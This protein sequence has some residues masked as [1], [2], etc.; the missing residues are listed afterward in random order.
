MENKIKS[1]TRIE[2]DKK[3]IETLRKNGKYHTPCYSECTCKLCGNQYTYDTKSKIIQKYFDKG[4]CSNECY[5]KSGEKKIDKMRT[6]LLNL[7]IECGDNNDVMMKYSDYK[8]EKTKKCADKWRETHIKKYGKDFAS[9]R[10]KLSWITHIKNFLINNSIVTEDEYN[11]LTDD[12]IHNLF[13]DN[14]NPI[15]SHG[16]LIKKGRMEKYGNDLS[17]YKKSYVIGIRNGVINLMEK[18]IGKEYLDSIDSDTYQELFDE[19][20]VYYVSERRKGKKS[21]EEL[22]K[23]KKSH[24]INNGFSKEMVKEM[25]DEEISLKYGEYISI[26]RKKLSESVL[27]GYKNTKKGWFTFKKFGDFFYRSSW[28][29]RVCQ[30]LDD[31]GDEISDVS[32]PEPITY[33]LDGKIHTYFSDFKITFK[34]G[35]IIYTEVKPYKKID[36]KVNKIKIE[37]GKETWGNNFHVLTENEIFS[38][39]LKNI[40]L[41]F[42]K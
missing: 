26:R 27:N 18:E 28:E 25:S 12:E 5:Q 8:S 32:T 35:V 20:Y 21:H 41:D 39:E 19:Y 30:E 29:E 3:R 23:W 33:V 7:G 42:S 11:N 24:L 14:F 40:I 4:Y 10:S 1:Q 15:T 2:S 16:D 9:S 38:G 34:N 31:L 17:E 13:I 37:R 36:E 6:E 22:I